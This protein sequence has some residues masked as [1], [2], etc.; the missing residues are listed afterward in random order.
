MQVPGALGRL[1]PALAQPPLM[2]L[3]GGASRTHVLSHIRDVD[4]AVAGGAFTP[5]SRDAPAPAVPARDTRELL[6]GV[7]CGCGAED[8]HNRMRKC[9]RCRAARYCTPECQ[10]S[11]W[12][13]HRAECRADSGADGTT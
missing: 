11:H 12:K 5:A 2:Q 7:C 1:L 10:R 3:D 6:R 8:P 13:V 4:P 9:A